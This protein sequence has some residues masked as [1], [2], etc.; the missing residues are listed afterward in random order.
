ME[1]AGI[2]A[3][4]L[5]ATAPGI[6][7]ATAEATVRVARMCNDEQARMVQ[8]HPRRFGFLAILPMP[9][10]DACLREID[11]AFGELSADGIVFMSNY[12]GE[13]IGSPRFWPVFEE[14]NRRKAVVLVHPTLPLGYRG[15]PGV[16]L[17]TMEFLFDTA[18]AMTSML[19][20]GTPEKYAGVRMIWTHAGGAMPYIAGRMAVLSRRN[21]DFALSGDG[22]FPA[23]ARF[24]YDVTQ[25]LAAPTFVGLR[26]VAAPDRLLFG[27]DCPMAREPQVRAALA[28]LDRLNL[29]SSERDGLERTNALALFPR[30]A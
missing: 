10:I 3:A 15:F 13:Y 26:A 4:V 12:G 16:S 19:Y 28:D 24:Y 8:A 25:S 14:L 5:S 11:R 7:M 6:T 23:L 9:D 2:D 20:Y 30:L 17:S 18:R 21:K 29:S 1:T 22:L 27:S